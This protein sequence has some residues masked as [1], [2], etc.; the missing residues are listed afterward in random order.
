MRNPGFGG[1]RYK[2]KLG[3]KFIRDTWKPSPQPVSESYYLR[4]MSGL[5]IPEFARHMGELTGQQ[6]EAAEAD[7]DTVARLGSLATIPFP[8]ELQDW[9]AEE[10]MFLGYGVGIDTPGLSQGKHPTLMRAFR[11]ADVAAMAHQ[12]RVQAM[13]TLVMA[14]ALDPAGNHLVAVRLVD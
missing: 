4:L 3:Y 2:A 5:L 7:G 8:T 9:I 6:L 10:G 1:V 12:I 14:T 11:E 13:N